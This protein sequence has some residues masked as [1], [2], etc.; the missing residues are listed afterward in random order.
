MTQKR[1][2]LRIFICLL[3]LELSEDKAA[4]IVA[5]NLSSRGETLL[6]SSVAT[7]H[8]TTLT[9]SRVEN[10][11][12]RV[13]RGDGSPSTCAGVGDHAG[14]EVPTSLPANA[15]AT[16]PL[17]QHAIPETDLCLFAIGDVIS[18]PLFLIMT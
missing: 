8:F 4:C 10:N 18:F 9:A 1:S 7:E 13:R 2:T 5:S 15:S 3:D 14:K 11:S 17:T 16:L 12:L 6:G